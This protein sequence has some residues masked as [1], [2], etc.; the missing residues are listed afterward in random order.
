V[1]EENKGRSDIELERRD[2]FE[3]EEDEL[4]FVGNSDVELILLQRKG[5]GDASLKVVS[6][7]SGIEDSVG[8]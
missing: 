2:D 3:M 1:D 7:R 8:V 4:G 6:L 5:E